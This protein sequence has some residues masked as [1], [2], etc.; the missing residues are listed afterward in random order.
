MLF[1][2]PVEFK[3]TGGPVSEVRVLR[4]QRKVI[5]ELK[6]QL[7]QLGLTLDHIKLFERIKTRAI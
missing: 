6:E 2:K 7:Q 5:G 1:E 3:A 4:A